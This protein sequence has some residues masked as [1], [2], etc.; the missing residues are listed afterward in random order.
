MSNCPEC[1]T[2]IDIPAGTKAGE[3]IIC[4]ECSAELEVI[5]TDPVELA[6]APD[7]EEDW[8]E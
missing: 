4:A 1:V 5:A 8:G 7:I 3:I 6:L 2:K